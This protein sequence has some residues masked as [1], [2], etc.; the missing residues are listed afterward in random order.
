M[1][2]EWRKHEKDLYGV[3]DKPSLIEIPQQ[4]YI[5][6]S[7]KGNPNEDDFSERVSVLYSLAYPI[8]MQY[9]AFCA[10]LGSNMQLEYNDYTVFPLEGVWTSSNPENPLDKDSFVYT[11]MIKQPAFITRDMFEAAYEVVQRKKSHP[12][13]QEV[14]FE[15]IGDGLCIQILHNGPFDNEPESVAKMDAFTKENRLE[16]INYYHREIYLTDPRKTVPEKG[17]T[18]LRYQV[19]KV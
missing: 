8:K 7:G 12:L 11:I 16:R 14:A 1:K 5:T 19:Q 6:I 13:L 3:K 15:E 10:D 17:K 18:I 4:N 2:Y 9:K